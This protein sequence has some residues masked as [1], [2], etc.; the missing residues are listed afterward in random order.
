MLTVYAVSWCPH[1]KRLVHFLT[2]NHI[3]FIYRD[4]EHQ[5]REIVQQV[6]AANGGQDWVVPTL[7]YNGKWRPGKTH[8]ESEL[9]TDL[10]KWGLL[11]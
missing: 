7:E 4:I 3:D 1:C 6:I 9:R 5:P 8:N 10:G 11:K 2:E